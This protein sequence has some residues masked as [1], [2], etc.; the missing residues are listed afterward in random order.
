MPKR[1]NVMLKPRKLRPCEACKE[2]D[3]CAYVCRSS[4]TCNRF[5]AGEWAGASVDD[6]SSFKATF[7]VKTEGMR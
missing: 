3:T 1:R 2:A 5:G 7:E 4:A 6:R